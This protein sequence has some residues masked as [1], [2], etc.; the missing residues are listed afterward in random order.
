MPGRAPAGTW[1]VAPR[2]PVAGP[3]HGGRRAPAVPAG[4]RTGHRIGGARQR[5]LGPKPRS[6]AEVRRKDGPVCCRARRCPI[7]PPTA[8]S[9]CSTSWAF[10][11]P[12]TKD[13]VAAVLESARPHG[14]ALIVLG[15]EDE[16]VWRSFRNLGDSADCLFARELNVYDVL[17]ADYVVF[18][19]ETLPAPSRPASRQRRRSRSRPRSRRRRG[20]RRGRGRL[21][22]GRRGRRSLLGGRRDEGRRRRCV[23]HAM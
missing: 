9:S 20:Q 16:V 2:S 5:R 3:S 10:E 12:K 1:S 19:R 22:G 7:G 14:K 18:T 23:I 13:A 11:T 21:L 17:V 15:E 8:R 4:R 6:F